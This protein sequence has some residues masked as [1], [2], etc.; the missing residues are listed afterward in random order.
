[1]KTLSRIP[2]MRMPSRPGS[3]PAKQNDSSAASVLLIDDEESIVFTWA[4]ILKR[5][6]MELGIAASA[7][8]AIQKFR[9][10][11]WDVIVTDLRRA[12]SAGRRILND[13]SGAAPA[14]IAIVLTGYP[15][16]ESAISAIRAGVHDYLT[17]PCKVEDMLA[18][19]KR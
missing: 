8:E 4:E 3:A 11:E 5:H 14:T 10:R 12:E 15:T 2:P 6:G 9:E 1:K 13:S 16:L 7:R 19:V 17:K 18:S